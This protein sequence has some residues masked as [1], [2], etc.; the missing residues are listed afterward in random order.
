VDPLG[1]EACRGRETIADNSA[2]LQPHPFSEGSKTI[3]IYSAEHDSTSALARLGMP[4][5]GQGRYA[6]PPNM[7]RYDPL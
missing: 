1:T 4:D 2:V 5:E 3:K 7:A 6:E